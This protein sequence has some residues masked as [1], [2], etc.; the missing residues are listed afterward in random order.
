MVTVSAVTY[1]LFMTFSTDVNG[2]DTTRILV[3]NRVEVNYL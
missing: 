3:K 2:R 1:L